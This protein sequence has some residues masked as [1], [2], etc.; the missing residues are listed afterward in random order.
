MKLAL[1]AV[2]V[3]LASASF[4]EGAFAQNTVTL[5]QEDPQGF[6][7]D[8]GNSQY[9][10]IGLQVY[11]AFVPN[12]LSQAFTWTP[13]PGV[14]NGFKVCSLNICLSDNGGGKVV[15][16]GQ[17]DVFTITNQS[18]VLDESTGKYIEQP[19]N[20]G[21]G[22]FLSMGTTP[23]AWTF[24]LAGTG[25]SSGGGSTSGQVKIMPLGDSITEGAATLATY[26][27]GGYRCPLDFL[28]QGGG[29]AFSF[30]GDSASL[31][32]GVVTGCSAVN[33]E[34][35]GGYDIA[36]IQN[37]AD[38]DAS[39]RT[40][41]PDIVLLL[42][43]TNDVAQGETSSI[44][45][46]L[47][48][49]LSNIYSQDPNAWV[50]ISTIPPMN[51]KAPSAPSAEAGWAPQVPQANAQIK[52]VAAQ[53]PRTTLIDF[54]SAVVTNVGANIGSDGVHPSV[55]GYGVLANL[56]SNAITA[57]LAGK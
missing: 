16:S 10:Q 52:A 24:A 13:V 4:N 12:E 32:S 46:Q 18:A 41:Q 47:R 23:A 21:D 22:S 8:A 26:A 27:Q 25:G 36:S 2:A 14:S 6:F 38:T 9:G 57:H 43:G 45:G 54:Y 3:C 17:A 5:T 15:M 39:I 28:L 30:V 11:Q 34:G 53:F 7:W 33:W 31:E 1:I 20:P 29:V 19:S 56:W 40:F 49:L 48:N 35:H 51:P 50:I 42:A 37:F 44:S 55:T